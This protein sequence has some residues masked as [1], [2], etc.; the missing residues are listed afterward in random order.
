MI[1]RC[2]N[3]TTSHASKYWVIILCIN[4][5][6]WCEM[7]YVDRKKSVAVNLTCVHF[8]SLYCVLVDCIDFSW[9][10]K[11]ILRY[12][13]ELIHC[14]FFIF[15]SANSS[16]Y[17]CLRICDQPMKTR[18]RKYFDG[19][20]FSCYCWRLITHRSR[21]MWVGGCMAAWMGRALVGGWM[22]SVWVR[23]SR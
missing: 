10:S 20:F 19:L 12:S 15:S 7:W 2:V 23:V 6:I 13:V 14:S 9:S 11:T 18:R 17:G 4:Q 8:G 5:R 16:K 21:Q 3:E 22:G 1:E